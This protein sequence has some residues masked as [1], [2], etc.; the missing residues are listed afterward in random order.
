MKSIA[1]SQPR[2]LPALNYLQRIAI[3]DVFVLLDNVQRQSR[4]IEN[5]NKIL[6]SGKPQWLTIP[7]AS[8]SR[9]K[10][11]NTV[12]S[13]DGWIEHHK[14]SL[15][16][17]YCKHP[18]YN[19]E[20]IEAYYKDL[21][22]L[23][24]VDMIETMLTN[25]CEI[26]GIKINFVRTSSLSINQDITGVENLYVISKDLKA[27]LYL[28]GSNGRDYGVKECFE[29]NQP[30]IKVLFHDFDYPVYAQFGNSAQNFQPWLCFFDPLFNLGTDKIKELI[31][32][33]PLLRER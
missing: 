7:I 16:F 6:T 26:F 31:F 19:R 27:D 17:T 1:I 18:Y 13:N 2:Y 32:N 30:K 12:V 14:K 10:I 9:E 15:H 25:L 23:N 11:Q 21:N 22:S 8:S 24:Y 4:G 33:K 28:S 5:R 29:G 20:L 3:T